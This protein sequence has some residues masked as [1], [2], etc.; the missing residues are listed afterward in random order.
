MARLFSRIFGVVLCFGISTAWAQGAPSAPPAEPAPAQ[1]ATEQPPA[2]DELAYALRPE[3]IKIARLFQGVWFGRKTMAVAPCTPATPAG[4]AIMGDLHNRV[5]VALAKD[6]L[7]SSVAAMD[8]PEAPGCPDKTAS[9]KLAQRANVEYL[10]LVELDES[11][12]SERQTRVVLHLLDDKGNEEGTYEPEG[13]VIAGPANSKPILKARLRTRFQRQAWTKDYRV[14]ITRVYQRGMVNT[15]T[16]RTPIIMDPSNKELL[17][18]DVQ[19]T[20]GMEGLSGRASTLKTTDLLS[21]I[22]SYARWGFCLGG[23]L[24][25]GCLGGLAAI[26]VAVVGMTQGAGPAALGAIVGGLAGGVVLGCLG[27]GVG[28]VAHF[29]RGSYVDQAVNIHNRGVA[30]EMGLDPK[31]MDMDEEYFPE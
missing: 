4:Q 2:G 23:P 13:L 29:A 27:G 8:G 17:P 7:A 3:K 1:A 30:E 16:T 15:F 14:T 19:A 12:A 26:P 24:T 5:G 25:G 22:L 6:G 28:L 11:S 31:D 10:I 20:P 9:R 18:D 21:T